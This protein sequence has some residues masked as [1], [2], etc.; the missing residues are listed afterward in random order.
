MPDGVVNIV[1]G[2]GATGA[3]IVNHPDINKIAFT[4]IYQCWQNY[5]KCN[6]RHR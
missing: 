2:A 5:S 6:C 3:A 1:T 4:G